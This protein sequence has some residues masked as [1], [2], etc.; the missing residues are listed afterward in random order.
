MVIDSSAV[1]AI[2]LDEPEAEQF[3]AQLSNADTRLISAASVL[4][5]SIVLESRNGEAGGRELDLF[6][7]RAQIDIVSV[8][9]E[10]V[11]AARAAWRKYGKS[12]HR[13]TLNF[14]DCLVYA[15]AKVTG[16]PILAKGNDFRLTDIE[17]CGVS[18]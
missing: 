1:I 10:Q 14:G 17:M 6:L 3:I 5:T 8:D 12:R 13:A 9:R 18:Q 11:E 2:I 16:E 4:E 7:N 15:L